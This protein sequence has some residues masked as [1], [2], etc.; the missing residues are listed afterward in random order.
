MLS[1]R[2]INVCGRTSDR[3]DEQLKVVVG[4]LCCDKRFTFIF[5]TDIYNKLLKVVRSSK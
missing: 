1:K 3:R 5:Y 4:I 2:I